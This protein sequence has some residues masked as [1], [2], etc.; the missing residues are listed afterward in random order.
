MLRNMIRKDEYGVSPVIAVILMVAI[1][2]VLS[3]VLWAMLTGLAPDEPDSVKIPMSNPIEKTYAWQLEITEVSGTLNLEDAKFLV[4]DNEGALVYSI[5][6]NNAN[7]SAFTK[8]KSTVYA[9]TLGPNAVKDA[10]NNTIDGDDALSEY[11]G[12]YIVYLDQ[13]SDQKVNAGDSIYVYKDNDADG[14]EEVSA[15][16]IFRIMANSDMAGEKGL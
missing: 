2:V 1:T 9:M 8:G 14:I 4:I 10:S 5:T 11:S 7:P 16:Y 6:T 15:N 13:N 3:G 12:C